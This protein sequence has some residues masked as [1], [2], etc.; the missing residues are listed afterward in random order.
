VVAL[1][2]L[3][4]PRGAEVEELTPAEEEALHADAAE[5]QAA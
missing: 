5:P 2:L 3:P 4:T 1:A